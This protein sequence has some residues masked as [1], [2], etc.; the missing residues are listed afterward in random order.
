MEGEGFNQ[1]ICWPIEFSKINDE[2]K[3]NGTWTLNS[4]KIT[5]PLFKGK[6]QE[7]TTFSSLRF[8]MYPCKPEVVELLCNVM[9]SGKFATHSK[10]SCRKK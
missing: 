4:A 3:R 5:P 2:S 8:S 10:D 1:K 6:F 9:S 7:K